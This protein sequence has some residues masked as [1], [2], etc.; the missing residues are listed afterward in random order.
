[1]GLYLSPSVDRALHLPFVNPFRFGVREGTRACLQE[2]L[3]SHKTIIIM[4]IV[5]I[6]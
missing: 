3:L 1:M 2:A 4:T 6:L 5:S